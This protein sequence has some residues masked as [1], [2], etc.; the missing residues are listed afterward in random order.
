MSLRVE[1]GRVLTMWVSS[2]LFQ[3]GEIASMKTGGDRMCGMFKEGQ[4][5]QCDEGGQV[6]RKMAAREKAADHV[7]LCS[8]G[9]TWAFTLREA[10]KA[11][12]QKY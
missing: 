8:P 10:E 3:V 7:G 6:Q 5:S 12:L 2:R 4:G 11:L 9:R 1:E